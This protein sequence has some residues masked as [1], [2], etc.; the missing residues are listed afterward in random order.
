MNKKQEKLFKKESKRVYKLKR[1]FES[2]D[3]Y[4][5]LVYSTPIKVDKWTLYDTKKEVTV[6]DSENNTIDELKKF[7]KAHRKYKMERVVI[8]T[9]LLL[10][11]VCLF[12]LT[13]NIIFWKLDS[14]R[15]FI[16][17]C[18]FVIILTSYIIQRFIN[19]NFRV[20]LLE[21]SE[22]LHEQFKEFYGIDLEE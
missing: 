20:D 22:D 17:G 12:F 9:N 8:F 14:I 15:Y 4:H 10:A 2:T 3:K 7:A 11:C 6:L 5:L 16:Y 18:E 21:Y 1:I 19:K 13:L